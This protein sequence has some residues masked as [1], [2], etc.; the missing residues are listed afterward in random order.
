MQNLRVFI[1]DALYVSGTVNGVDK[2][3]T[4]EEGNLWSTI[5]DRSTDGVYRIALSIIYGD[6][7]TATY[8]VT[9][10]YGLVLITDR[11]QQDVTNGT[12]KGSYNASDLNRVGAA[13]V[14]LR[15]RFNDNGYDIQINPKTDWKEIDVPVRSDMSIYLGCLGTLRNAINLPEDV[16]Q[17]PKSMIELNYITANNIEKILESVDSALSKSISF[18]WYSGDLYSGEV[19]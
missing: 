6:G 18:L 11:T 9:L 2:V 14:Y 10:Y 3:W 8:S 7:K 15:D 1:D 5:A 16:P 4:R 12:R 13:M 19:I 17:T